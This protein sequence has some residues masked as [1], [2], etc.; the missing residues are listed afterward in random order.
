MPLAAFVVLAVASELLRVCWPARSCDVSDGRLV[1]ADTSE[2]KRIRSKNHIE[3][4]QLLDNMGGIL[5]E[6]EFLTTDALMK[7]LIPALAKVSQC[8]VFLLMETTL[9]K[10]RRGD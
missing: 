9:D 4:R 6:L 10:Q 7:W 3:T 2:A 1:C 5:Y 8:A